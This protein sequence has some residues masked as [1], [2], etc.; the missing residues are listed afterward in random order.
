M[1]LLDLERRNNRIVF[2]YDRLFYLPDTDELSQNRSFA[3]AAFSVLKDSKAYIKKNGKKTVTIES[4]EGFGRL[5]LF[6]YD[7]EYLVI[8]GYE[9][10]TGLKVYVSVFAPSYPYLTIE[11]ELNSD[12]ELYIESDSKDFYH[13]DEID[14]PADYDD[15]ANELHS[16][17]I[18]THYMQFGNNSALKDAEKAIEDSDN[19]TGLL[20][21]SE[22]SIEM[23]NLSKKNTH[24]DDKCAEEN[25]ENKNE[26]HSLDDI[27][28]TLSNYDFADNLDAYLSNLPRNRISAEEIMSAIDS[29]DEYTLYESL[30]KDYRSFMTKDETGRYAEKFI[31]TFDIPLEDL[32]C[33]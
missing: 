11:I 12:S 9:K 4:V 6:D 15:C 19:K 23:K 16:L 32:P 30:L 31:R 20:Y 24:L 22:Y 14:I 3:V 27:F 25:L 21:T 33:D 29:Y 13:I 5:C 18:A 10:E 17:L 26:F 8:E 7:N 2:F 1:K 28:S